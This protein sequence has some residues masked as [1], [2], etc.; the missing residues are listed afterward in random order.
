[1]CEN[2]ASKRFTWPGQDESFI[3]DEH[4]P[5]L[6]GVAKAIGLHLQVITL[7]EEELKKGLTCNQKGR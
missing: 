5:K 4:A 1:M 2:P 6:V 7:T 3:C